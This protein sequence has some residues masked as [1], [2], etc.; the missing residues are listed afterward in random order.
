[1]IMA[2]SLILGLSEQGGGEDCSIIKFAV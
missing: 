2:D 1:M